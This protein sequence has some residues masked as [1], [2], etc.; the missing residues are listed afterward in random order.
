[1]EKLRNCNKKILL[2]IAQL[3]SNRKLLDNK[4]FKYPVPES[5]IFQ[6]LKQYYL[7]NTYEP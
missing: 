6:T 3:A 1:M 2:N 7:A 4:N 5:N